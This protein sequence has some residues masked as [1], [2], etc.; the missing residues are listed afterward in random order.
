MQPKGFRGQCWRF[1]FCN[2]SFVPVKSTE[3]PGDI[4]GYGTAIKY[5]LFNIIYTSHYEKL[6]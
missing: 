3:I 1:I 2:F 6:Q 5:K 4:P